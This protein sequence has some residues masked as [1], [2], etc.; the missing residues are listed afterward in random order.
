M[1]AMERLRFNVSNVSKT[2][3]Q[4]LV[5][6]IKVTFFSQYYSASLS[7]SADVAPPPSLPLPGISQLAETHGC[8]DLLRSSEDYICAHFPAVVAADEFVRL[9]VSSIVRLLAR[10]ELAVASEACVL[11]AAVRWLSA[12]ASRRRGHVAAVLA[13]VR[14]SLVSPAPLA[15]C[16]RR[17]PDTALRLCVRKAARQAGD[18]QDVRRGARRT[19]YV[20]GGFRRDAGAT[21]SDSEVLDSVYAFCGDAQRWTALA[22]L[23]LPRSGHAVAA[24]GGAIYAIGGE[25]E[26]LI[27]AATE[28]YDVETRSWHARANMT[29]PRCGLG[30]C[31][32]GAAIYAIGGWVG[33]E[34]GRSIERYDPQLDV[35][36]EVD[37]LQK[38][39][40]AMGIVECGGTSFRFRFSDR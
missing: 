37:T 24:C 30:V 5:D 33:S 6:G 19:L 15:A 32:V 27:Y 34:I 14:L 13:S 25:H 18:A 26:S 23:L 8:T 36:K 22:P 12:D 21:W 7:Q 11:S 29:Q 20:V 31:T 16:L 3:E 2:S 17:C 1:E 28:R 10:E 40:F 35:W 38:L 9:S 4:L 39:R